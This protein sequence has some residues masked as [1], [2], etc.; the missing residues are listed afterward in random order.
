MSKTYEF[1]KE[2]KIFYLASIKDN[3]PAIRPFGA[4]MEYENELYFSTANTKDVYS[5]L[6]NNSAIQIVALKNGTREWI[7]IS[8]KAVEVNDFKI[9]Q[10]MLNACPVLIKHFNTNAC[11]YF[12]LFKITEMHVLLNTDNGIIEL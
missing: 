7:R 3:S 11:P 5:Q 9:K 8:G 10:A 1:L 4:V 2:C 6:S 12:A